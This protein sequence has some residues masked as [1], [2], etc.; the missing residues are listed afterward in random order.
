MEGESIVQQ[1]PNVRF[2]I[3]LLKDPCVVAFFRQ[4]GQVVKKSLFRMYSSARD[5]DDPDKSLRSILRALSDAEI[6]TKDKENPYAQ[7]WERAKSRIPH[8]EQTFRHGIQAYGVA[9]GRAY[10]IA[11]N[12][13]PTGQKSE[14]TFPGPDRFFSVFLSSVA[15]DPVVESGAFF[16]DVNNRNVILTSKFLDTLASCVQVDV[17]A[18]AGMVDLKPGQTPDDQLTVAGSVADQ[19]AATLVRGAG[20]ASVA[21]SGTALSSVSHG[22]APSIVISRKAPTLVI[23]KDHTTIE[24]VP[25]APEVSG[26]GEPDDLPDAPLDDGAS[27]VSAGNTY[28]D[29]FSL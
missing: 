29:A 11:T 19:V 26:G 15:E 27:H 21:S 7:E 23:K 3:S 1:D 16:R 17:R 8:I 4:M 24:E 14:I 2:G 18:Q 25:E 20:S 13:S 5:A 9:Y 22:G 12:M 6:D 28:V 10:A